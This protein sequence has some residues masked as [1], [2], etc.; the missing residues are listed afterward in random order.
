[1]GNQLDEII[2]VGGAIAAIAAIGYFGKGWVESAAKGMTQG[3]SPNITINGP[4]AQ[5]AQGLIDMYKK[6]ADDAAAW[7]LSLLNLQKQGNGAPA[8]TQGD[9][10]AAYRTGLAQGA[11]GTWS[12]GVNPYTATPSIFTIKGL[13]KYQKK[14][15]N[16]V[17][18]WSQPAKAPA[19]GPGPISGL[20]VVFNNSIG[21]RITIDQVMPQDRQNQIG[22][23]TEAQQMAA[24]GALE[25]KPVIPSGAAQD[26]TIWLWRDTRTGA[27][28]TEPR[29]AWEKL[30]LDQA[31]QRRY[32]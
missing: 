11:T 27:I 29:D 23:K 26:A 7:A 17:S 15:E 14:I 18:P 6:N 5:D 4:N 32:L 20:G 16:T 1:M 22:G 10:S 28:S 31:K 12:K 21:K 19:A 25:T 13:A 24:Y 30:T 8:P 9:V 2:L 3:L